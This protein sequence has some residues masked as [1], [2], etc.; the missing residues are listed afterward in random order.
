[1]ANEPPE[2]VDNQQ[3]QW[4]VVNHELGKTPWVQ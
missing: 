1:M 4:S 3:G 2:Q